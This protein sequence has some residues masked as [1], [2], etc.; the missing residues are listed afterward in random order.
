L[1]RQGADEQAMAPRKSRSMSSEENLNVGTEVAS[2]NPFSGTDVAGVLRER[3]WLSSEISSEQKAWCER[4]AF[5]LGPQA[6]D[7]EALVAL[8]RLVFEY[9]AAVAMASVEAHVVMTRYAARDVIRQLARLVLDGGTCTA[10]R[11]KE[12]VTAL[13]ERL[14][15]RG[16]EVLLPLRLAL[17]GRAGDGG[18]DRVILLLD[19]AA[20]AGFA[21]KT[22]RQRMIEFCSALD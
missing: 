7:R 10:E 6:A 13:K 8:L 2:M 22:V 20:G 4:A 16:R 3:R 11:F 1:E 17:A 21:V 14:D 19:A 5:L 12:I 15:L 18:L 9:D